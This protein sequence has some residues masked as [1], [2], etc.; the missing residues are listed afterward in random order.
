MEQSAMQRKATQARVARPGRA[1]SMSGGRVHRVPVTSAL[2]GEVWYSPT[3]A[4]ERQIAPP[5]ARAELS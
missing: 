4:C 2:A 3:D 5:G 1:P